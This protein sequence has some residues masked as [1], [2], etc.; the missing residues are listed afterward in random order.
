MTGPATILEVPAP[1]LEGRAKAQA[2]QAELKLALAAHCVGPHE[3]VQYRG[4]KPARC[5]AC[6]YNVSGYH[7]TEVETSLDR[8]RR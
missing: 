5:R 8:A 2:A 7:V 1:I 6:G 3:Y 4:G